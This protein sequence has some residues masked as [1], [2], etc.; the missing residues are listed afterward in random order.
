MANALKRIIGQHG[1][2]ISNSR[3]LVG[4]FNAHLRDCIFLFADEAFFAGDKQHVGVLNSLITDDTLTVE[5]KG[6]TSCRLRTT[7]T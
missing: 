5:G 4:N 7:C 2:T 1:L 6:A 3:H